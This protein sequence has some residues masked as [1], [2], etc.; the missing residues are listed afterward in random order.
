[1][2]LRFICSS[3]LA[4]AL[5]IG[6]AHAGTVLETVNRD[7]PASADGKMHTMMTYAQD[8]RMRVET[9]PGDTL[10][11][12]KDDTIFTVNNKDKSYYSMDRAAMKRMADQVNPAL[13]QMQDQL[14]KMP[15]EQRA[16]MEKM[17]GNRLPGMGKQQKSQEIRKTARTDKISGYTCSYVEVHEDGILSDELCVVPPGTVKGSQELMD[18]A[19][20]MSALLKDMLSSIDAP[21]LKQSV[22]K[23]VADYEKIGGLP[24]LTRHFADGKPTSETTLKSI[25]NEPVPAALFEIPAGYAKK[26]MMGRK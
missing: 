1:M 5:A 9:K 7:L 25:R 22:D 6:G 23:Q 12:F 14:A 15:P 2:N 8:G 3:A 18:A 19:A 4:L 16:Q 26:E 21:W 24:L 17:M 13:K 11:I 10:M 20:K